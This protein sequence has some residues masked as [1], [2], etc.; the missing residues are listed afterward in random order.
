MPG[1]DPSLFK[2]KKAGD[3]ITARDWNALVDLARREVTGPNVSS[4]SLGWQIMDVPL[5]SSSSAVYMKITT[6][7][8]TTPPYEY[9][10]KEVTRSSETWVDVAGGKVLS[11]GLFNLAEQGTSSGLA[12]VIVNDIVRAWPGPG[13]TH[14]FFERMN[15][16]GT[17][18]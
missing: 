5:G 6:V 16:R 3:P 8:R 7:A 9:S 18:G 11:G 10:A 14:W 13:T 17:Y 1:M 4:N 2:K 15:Y 12:K